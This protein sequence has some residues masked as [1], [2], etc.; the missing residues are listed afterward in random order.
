MTLWRFIFSVNLITII[1][2]VGWHMPF[3]VMSAFQVSWIV[4][5]LL[6]LILI[7]GERLI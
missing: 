6:I 1:L 5:F 4:F 2:G 7:I 3:A